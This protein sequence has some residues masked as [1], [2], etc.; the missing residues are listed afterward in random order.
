M[1]KHDRDLPRLV[2]ERETRFEQSL[3]FYQSKFRGYIPRCIHCSSRSWDCGCNDPFLF[4]D[5]D[6]KP[7]ESN[8]ILREQLE[9]LFQS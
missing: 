3:E 2:K 5:S 8:P 9:S 6:S 1:N 7:F 4:E